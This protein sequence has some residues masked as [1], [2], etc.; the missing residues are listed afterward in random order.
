MAASPK[1]PDGLE[2]TRAGLREFDA[3]DANFIKCVMLL[4]ETKSRSRGSEHLD[5]PE[6]EDSFRELMLGRPQPRWKIVSRGLVFL[7]VIVAGIVIKLALEDDQSASV[8]VTF[9][10]AGLIL[11]GALFLIQEFILQR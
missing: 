10:L 7:G 4:W 2:Y 3:Q 6:C 9:L 1:A 8:T 5:A 11:A